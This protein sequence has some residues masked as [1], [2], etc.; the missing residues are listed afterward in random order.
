MDK[1]LV[2]HIKQIV[3][4]ELVVNSL[5]I[6]VDKSYGRFARAKCPFHGGH[7]K[8]SF[9]IDLSTG[10]WSCFSSGCHHGY[11]DII[12]LVQLSNRCNFVD[13]VKYLAGIS[14]IDLDGDNSHLAYTALIKKDVTDFIRRSQKS[15]VELDLCTIS[16]I[17][18][19]VLGWIQNRPDYFYKKGYSHAIQDY[20]EVGGHLDYQGLPRACFPVRDDQGRIVAWDGRRIDNDDEPRYFLQ[21]RGFPKGQVLYHYHRA[22]DYMAAFNGVLFVV[23]GYKAC[24]SMVQAGYFNTVACM[25]AGLVAGQISLL[26]KNLTLKRIISVLDGDDAGRNGSRRMKRELGYLCDLTIIDMPD[27]HDPSTFVRDPKALHTIITPHI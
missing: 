25:G 27:E 22:K 5:G 16:N 8:T 18:E 17:E 23:E 15:E 13:A 20:F 11:S 1:G 21:P 9:S 2:E 14:G 4:A 6:D 10:H 3:D 12:G 19:Y 24:W 7:N 26:L